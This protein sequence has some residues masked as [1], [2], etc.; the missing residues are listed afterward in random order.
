MVEASP[1]QTITCVISLV[2]LV[3]GERLATTLSGGTMHPAGLA[4]TQLLAVDC[5]E[6]VSGTLCE[7]PARSSNRVLQP[8]DRKQAG[9]GAKLSA[10]RS[11]SSLSR[12]R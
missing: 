12:R 8:G 4:D 7:P 10:L 6:Q 5:M 9:E 3:I 2:S 1:A 11:L